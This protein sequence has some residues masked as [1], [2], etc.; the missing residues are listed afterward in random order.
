MLLFLPTI[1]S[2]LII[3][4]LLLNSYPPVIGQCQMLTIVIGG[5]QTIS[6]V[7]SHSNAKAQ[8]HKA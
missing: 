7:I 8:Q 2:N 4:L 3:I 1:N 6:D 5:T